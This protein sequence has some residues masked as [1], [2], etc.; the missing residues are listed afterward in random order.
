VYLGKELYDEKGGWKW[1]IFVIGDKHILDD[2]R[3]VTYTLHHTFPDPI[4]K[5]CQKGKTEKAFSHTTKGW[6]TFT[7]EVLI[8][9]KDGEAVSK[10][11]QLVFRK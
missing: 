5:V 6:G 7:V 9:F 1:T 3:C 11:H 10:K 2:I 8:S 4:R